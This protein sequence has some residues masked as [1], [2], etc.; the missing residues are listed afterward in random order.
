MAKVGERTKGKERVAVERNAVL[1]AEQ[2]MQPTLQQATQV[3]M[4]NYENVV[5]EYFQ[6]QAQMFTPLAMSV[7]CN[8]LP[9]GSVRMT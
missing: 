5:G 2:L 4:S 6:R 8:L 3:C 1:V 7:G 9:L